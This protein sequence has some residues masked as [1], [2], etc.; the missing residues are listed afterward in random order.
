[1]CTL[2]LRTVFGLTPSTPQRTALFQSY[3]QRVPEGTY[4]QNY[5]VVEE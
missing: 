5:K 1:M 3:T 4:F 2:D